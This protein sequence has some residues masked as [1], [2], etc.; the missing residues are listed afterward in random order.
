MYIAKFPLN[1][2]QR[3]RGQYKF[4]PSRKYQN[5]YGYLDLTKDNTLRLYLSLTS[6]GDVIRVN[7][8][9]HYIYDV[10]LLN[11]MYRP[12]PRQSKADDHLWLHSGAKSLKTE[13]IFNQMTPDKIHEVFENTLV[14]LDSLIKSSPEKERKTALN[15]FNKLTTRQWKVDLLYE[16]FNAQKLLNLK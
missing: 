8:A 5:S 11:L 6:K 13:L 7:I 14:G 1:V 9:K 10:L 12:I 4:E 3:D 2:L 16:M 15:Q